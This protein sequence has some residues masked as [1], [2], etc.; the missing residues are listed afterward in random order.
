MD[1]MEQLLAKIA[2]E[3]IRDEAKRSAKVTDEQAKK[4]AAFLKKWAKGKP[5]VRQSNDATF[6]A[7]GKWMSNLDWG[8]A[9]RIHDLGLGQLTGDPK[10]GGANLKF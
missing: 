4:E 5:V 3:N 8:V 9:Q 7:A 1:K 10:K 2:K 6:W